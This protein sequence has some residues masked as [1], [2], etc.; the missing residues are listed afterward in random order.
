[1]ELNELFDVK[2]KYN[3]YFNH[4]LFEVGDGVRIKYDKKGII[5]SIVHQTTKRPLYE[6]QIHHI[7]KFDEKIVVPEGNILSKIICPQ[8]LR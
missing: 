6:I 1:M 5:T 4:C 8:Y 3:K 2:E 7:Y